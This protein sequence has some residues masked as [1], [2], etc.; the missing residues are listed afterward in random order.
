MTYESVCIASEDCTEN[1]QKARILADQIT[2][3]LREKLG[4]KS[5][6]ETGLLDDDVYGT[7]LKL[8]KD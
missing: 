3:M 4:L 8:K 1:V 6:N 7:T 2:A 5:Q